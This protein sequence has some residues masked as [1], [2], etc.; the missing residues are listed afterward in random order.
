MISCGVIIIV[1]TLIS[2]NYGLG[3]LPH[4]PSAIRESISLDGIW[5]FALHNISFPQSQHKINVNLDLPLI[6]VPSSYNDIG[7]QRSTRDYAGAVTYSRT[8]FI[9]KSWET[10]RVWIRFGSVCYSADVVINNIHVISHSIGHLAF[11]AEITSVLNYGGENTIKVVVDN[12]LTDSTIPQGETT[13]LSNGMLARAYSFD[14]FD[15]AGIDRSVTIYTTS[16]SYVDDIT[17]ITKVNDSIGIIKYNVTVLGHQQKN[18]L[19]LDQNKSI[20]YAVANFW[21]EGEISIE[22]PHLWWPYAMH[23]NPGYLYTFRVDVIENDQLIDSYEQT[24]GFRDLTWDN[25]SF[26]INGKPIYFRGVGRHEDSD[27]RGKGT[28]LPLFIKDHNLLRWLGVNSYRTSHYPYCEEL[29]DLADQLGI[30]IINEVPSVNTDLFGDDLLE[31]HKKAFTELY[32]RDKNRP[33]VVAWS[34]ANEPRTQYPESGPYFQEVIEHMKS[35]DATRPVTAAIAQPYNVDN[36]G[37]YLDI[38][39]FNRYEAWYDNTG[40]L[41]GITERIVIEAQEWHNKY[42]KP[43]MVTEYGADTLEG[44][45]TLPTFIWSEEYQQSVM[46]RYFKAFDILR[47][48]NW[49]IGEH[50]WN[51]ADFKTAET[52]VRVG[53]NKKGIFTRNRQP[54]SSAFLLRKRYWALAKSLDGVKLPSDLQNYIESEYNVHSEL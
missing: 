33:S 21:P 47:Q 34:C 26:Y 30:L 45:H 20:V 54:K 40:D 51:F 18:I 2:G 14:F 11:N 36:I 1:L 16:E 25:E 53:G 35:L 44:L 5:N 29:M 7:T 6:P 9:P 27:I 3:I 43:V 42:N 46:S 41:D 52:Y 13:I 19:I 48:F 23:E 15:Y 49:F 50:I 37:Q 24:F 38:I 31:N 4:K 17:I 28:D 32:N 39:G 12:I 8:F 10:K 22:N